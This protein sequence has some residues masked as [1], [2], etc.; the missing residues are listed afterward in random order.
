M[1]NSTVRKFNN[2]MFLDSDVTQGQVQT[3]STFM[4]YLH[5]FTVLAQSRFKWT[6]LPPNVTGRLIERNLFQYGAIAFY[7]H[8][9]ELESNPV[10]D[11]NRDMFKEE[12]SMDSQYDGRYFTLPFTYD[13][14]DMYGDPIN[15]YAYGLNGYRHSIV[16]GVNAVI[17]RNNP[18]ASN[19]VDTVTMFASR[20]TAAL[21]TQDLNIHLQRKPVLYVCE[22]SQKNTL[23]QMM[24]QVDQFNPWIFG[25][26][27]ALDLDN[28]VKVINS[29]VP[30]IADKLTDY[31]NDLWSEVLEFFGIAKTSYK[32]ERLITNEVDSNNHFSVASINTMLES[33]RE[34]M[35]AINEMFGLDV[36]VHINDEADDLYRMMEQE[37]TNSVGDAITK[38][39]GE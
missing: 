29:E 11:G 18:I 7:K 31:K 2:P 27:N 13:T 16:S 33:R 14:L 22:E 8:N 23:K 19:T 38:D 34:A 20:L 35:Y 21:R 36:D 25:V 37:V 6:N 30:Y 10:K 15:L 9:T 26:K 39:G 3:F 4:N 24:K 28:A 1:Q 32:R 12:A 5:R 17:M